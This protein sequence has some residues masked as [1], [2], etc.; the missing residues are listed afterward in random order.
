MLMEK[1]VVTRLR[2]DRAHL[3]ITDITTTAST[4]SFSRWPKR[5]DHST[6]LKPLAT[7]MHP[8]RQ[9]YVEEEAQVSLT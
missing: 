6:I 7:M 5:I 9:A 3:L 4:S 8:A 2:I 1:D